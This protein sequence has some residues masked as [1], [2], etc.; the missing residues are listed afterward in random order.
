VSHWGYEARVTK[1]IGI[2]QSQSRLSLDGRGFTSTENQTNR[3]TVEGVEKLK[4]GGKHD[5]R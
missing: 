1:K 5:G 4:N 3:K 2:S